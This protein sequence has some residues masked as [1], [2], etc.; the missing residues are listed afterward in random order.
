MYM[1]FEVGRLSGNVLDDSG[2]P[3][4]F[5]TDISGR[6]YLEG[7][8][9]I[10]RIRAKKARLEQAYNERHIWDD[11]CDESQELTDAYAA[12]CDGHG[13]YK[14]FIEKGAGW[15][16]LYLETAEVLKEFRG[17][18]I[19]KAMVLETLEMFET[20]CAVVVLVAHPI[21]VH[22][23]SDQDWIRAM[24]WDELARTEVQYTRAAKKLRR[25][26]R[27]LGFAAV[28][29]TEHLMYRDCGTEH[30]VKH[31]TIRAKL[32]ALEP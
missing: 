32:A 15:D 8:R 26:W 23:P 19:G 10:G 31:A 25:H 24:R 2:E 13:V 11:V 14:D 7:G 6:L 27:S 29:Q 22:K 9:E 28:P 18:L 12:V 5:I 16:L 30:T 21:R 3:S 20:G 1:E 17:H 4:N